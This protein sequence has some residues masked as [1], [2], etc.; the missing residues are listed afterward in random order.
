MYPKEPCS[1]LFNKDAQEGASTS[2][3]PPPS[4]LG[5]AKGK[6]ALHAEALF[7]SSSPK[8]TPSSDAEFPGPKV[9]IIP[10]K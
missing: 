7:V 4:T 5:Q 3:S 2:E 6:P 10:L 9:A 1:T 8:P